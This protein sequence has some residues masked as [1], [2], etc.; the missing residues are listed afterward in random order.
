MWP[1]HRL[2]AIKLDAHISREDRCNRCLVAGTG[3]VTPVEF[4]IKQKA[5]S[6]GARIEQA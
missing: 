3:Q 5:R 6:T 4:D 1:D 2:S